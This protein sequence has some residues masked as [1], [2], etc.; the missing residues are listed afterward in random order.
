MI[1][2]FGRYKKRTFSRDRRIS[3]KSLV[4]CHFVIERKEEQNRVT[5][6]VSTS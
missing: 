6:L 1:V 2:N 5:N 4:M 3:F